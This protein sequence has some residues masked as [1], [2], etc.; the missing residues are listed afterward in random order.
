MR[1][2]HTAICGESTAAF[3]DSA[4]ATASSNL[5]EELEL[6]MPLN[7]LGASYEDVIARISFEGRCQF[8]LREGGSV[9]QIVPHAA[10]MGTTSYTWP[11]AAFTISLY[12]RV[13]ERGRE[14]EGAASQYRILY[15]REWSQDGPDAYRAAARVTKGVSDLTHAPT[16]A[17]NRAALGVIEDTLVFDGVQDDSTLDYVAG[18]YVRSGNDTPRILEVSGVPWVEAFAIERADI[19]SL[20]PTWANSAIKARVIEVTKDWRSQLIDLVVVEVT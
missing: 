17:V 15:G 3:D 16:S 4:K 2:L 20:T 5:D 10:V 9:T 1:H 12:Q 14:I 7:L 8:L 19:V 6:H 13:R 11:A 18:Y